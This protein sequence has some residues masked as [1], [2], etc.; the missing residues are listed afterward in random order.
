[1]LSFCIERFN[2]RL[3]SER[4]GRDGYDVVAEE[5]CLHGPQG[6]SWQMRV[7]FEAQA[8][9]AAFPEVLRM[10]WPEDKDGDE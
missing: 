2:A 6:L 9:A 5:T 1:M 3:R 8:D 10:S 4:R 7:T